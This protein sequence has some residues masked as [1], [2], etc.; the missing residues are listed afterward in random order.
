MA[1]WPS[2][3]VQLE[4]N[5]FPNDFLMAKMDFLDNVNIM[6]YDTS[7]LWN[8]NFV[9]FISKTFNLVFSKSQSATSIIH[10]HKLIQI[11]NQRKPNLFNGRCYVAA[12]VLQKHS[13]I[14]MIQ[15][16]YLTNHC[17]SRYS[18]FSLKIQFGFQI[19]PT[20]NYFMKCEVLQF[21][22]L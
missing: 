7:L 19:S 1:E 8:L 15:I 9:T 3:V 16:P 22:K 10:T 17:F 12:H 21:I 5:H 6:S 13:L 11:M 2:I 14:F 4:H 18:L 20:S